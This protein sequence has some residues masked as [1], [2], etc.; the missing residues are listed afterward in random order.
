MDWAEAF[1]AMTC[2]AVLLSDLSLGNLMML[3]SEEIVVL[4][5]SVVWMS[6]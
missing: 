2:R 1:V 6:F 3:L 5:L 4:A